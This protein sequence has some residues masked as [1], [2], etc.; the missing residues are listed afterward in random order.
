M[1]SSDTHRRYRTVWNI[2]YLE[3]RLELGL[4]PVI[5]VIRSVE[6]GEVQSRRCFYSSHRCSV[7]QTVAISFV[8]KIVLEA[9]DAIYGVL[10]SKRGAGAL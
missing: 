7:Q 3:L 1:D 10:G 8:E 6:L 5:F 4:F 2:L 9:S